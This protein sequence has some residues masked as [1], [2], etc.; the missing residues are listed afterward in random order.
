MAGRI[1]VGTSSWAD[2]GFVKEWYPPGMP[3]A[4][5]LPWY[6]E[7]FEAVELNASFYAVPDRSTVQRW[8]DVTPDGF[9]FDVKL[10]RLLSR[11]GAG[12]DSLPPTLR[13][14]ARTTPRGRVVLDREIELALAEELLAAIAP[15]EDAGRL[16][17]LLLQTTPAFKPRREG[18]APESRG[19]APT[20]DPDARDRARGSDPEAFDRAPGAA[21]PDRLAELEPLLEVLA[22]RRV[23][24]ELRNRRWV[25]DERL[26]A[27]LAWC[28]E[29]GVAFVCVDAPPGEHFS[30]MPAVDAVTRDDLAY[31]RLHGRDT[32]GYLHGRSVAERFGWVYGEQELEEVA[33]RVHALAEQATEVHVLFNNNRDD[34]APSAARRFR[35]LLGQDPGP[36]PEPGQLRLG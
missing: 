6:A 12:L 26:P 13:D 16:G 21:D 4:Q 24:L 11:H 30:I 33:G 5:R 17:A 18:E 10:H 31:V 36:P 9:V 23:A 35:A 2:P 28:S 27:T 22:P 34:D 14:R 7:R 15:L 19:D 25:S 3:A 32:Q 29:H 1:L 20:W 8:V